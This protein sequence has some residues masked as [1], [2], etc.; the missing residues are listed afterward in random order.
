[1][2]TGQSYFCRSSR[3]MRRNSHSNEVTASAGLIPHSQQV[4]QASTSSP[5]LSPLPEALWDTS[6]ITMTAAQHGGS[7]AQISVSDPQGCVKSILKMTIRW[8]TF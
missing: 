1:M 4:C 8:K 5:D 7:Q 2:A 3:W 6:A